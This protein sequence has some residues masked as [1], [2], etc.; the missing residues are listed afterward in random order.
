[1]SIKFELNGETITAK[2]NE[3]IFKAAQRHGVEIPH[4]CYRDDLGESG[5]CRACMV[6]IEGES[7]RSAD[8]RRGYRAADS[9]SYPDCQRC[10]P[11][12]VLRGCP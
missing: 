7:T 3:T 8:G 10:N 1:M 2:E 4:L 9:L 12:R 6:E 5:N 11:P